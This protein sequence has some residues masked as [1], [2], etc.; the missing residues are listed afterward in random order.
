MSLKPGYQV[1]MRVDRVR[2]FGAFLTDERK[3][4]EVFLHKREMTREVSEGD[5][6]TVFLY[7]DHK[8]RL[9]GTMEEPLLTVGEFAWLE[10]VAVKDGHGLFLHNGVSRDLF[11]SI[12]ELPTDRSIWPQVGDRLPVSLT[13]DKKGR[14]MGKLVKGQP[15]ED[16]ANKATNNLRKKEVHGT[17]YHFLDDGAVLFT[18]EGYLGYLHKTE[19]ETKPRLGERITARVLYIR[20]DGRINVTTF[21]VRT[22]RQKGDADVIFDYLLSRGGAMPFSDRTPPEDIKKRFDMSKASFKRALGK[23]L[24]EGKVYQEDGWTY[25]KES[26]EQ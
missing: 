26:R 10:V 8:G 13:W 18:E 24:K 5:E 16:Q 23:L 22:E 9:A 7:H 6:V 21:P 20:E 15:L 17:V 11:L 25:R 3:Q 2:D 12:D 1:T 19:M 14:L 4:E